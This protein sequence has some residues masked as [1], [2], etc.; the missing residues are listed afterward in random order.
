MGCNKRI[1]SENSY[2]LVTWTKSRS[3][4]V[5]TEHELSLAR[6]DITYSIMLVPLTI[7]TQMEDTVLN[8][9]SLSIANPSSGGQKAK[10]HIPEYSFFIVI[11]VET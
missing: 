5:M 9:K 6:R 3:L 11:A 2:P 7:R 4:V 1:R 8:L 10:G